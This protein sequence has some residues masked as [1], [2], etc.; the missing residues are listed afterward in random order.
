MLIENE[1]FLERT[2]QYFKDDQKRFLEKLEQ[3]E[4]HALFLNTHKATKE[5]ILSLIDFKIWPSRLCDDSFYYECDSVGKSK[6]YELGLIYP[7]DVA[8]SLSSA[9]A[10]TDKIK[11]IVDLCAAPGGKTIDIL[12]RVKRDVLCISN[13]YS[14]SRALTLSSN[15]ERLGFSNVI[16]TNKNTSELADQLENFADLVILDAPCSGEGMIR[17]YPEILDTYSLNNIRSLAELQ[18]SL[19]DDAY[20]ILKPSGQLIYSTCTYAFEEDEDQIESFLERYSDMEL[21]NIDIQSSSKLKGTVKLSPLYDTEGQFF[22]LMCKKGTCADISLRMLKPVKEKLVDDFISDNLS[23]N[24][25]YLY[26]NNDHYYL[27]L[28]PLPDLKRNVLKYG[29]YLGEV[30]NKRFEPSHNLYRADSLMS[31]F[32]YRYDLSDKEYDLFISG[33]EVRKQ[34]DKHHYLVT[35]KGFPLGFVKSSNGSLKNKYPKGLRNRNY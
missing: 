34:L 10:D 2:K 19:L 20:R 18:S 33:N 35:Y 12:N 21:V 5:K 17:K 23:I 9:F 3:E 15:L 22:A 14:H 26:K 32:N 1:L 30:I 13:D 6:V 8:A 4:S 28:E 16:I 25:Y 29:I 24:E 31:Y 11:T 27:S 7:Q